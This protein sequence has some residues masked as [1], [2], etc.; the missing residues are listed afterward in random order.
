[1]KE[2]IVKDKT[3]AFALRIVKFYRIFTETKR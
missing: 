1:M 3:F 2:K